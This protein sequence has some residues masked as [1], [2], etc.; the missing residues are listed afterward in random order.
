MTCKP[1]LWACRKHSFFIF[2]VVICIICNCGGY[3]VKLEV[4]YHAASIFSWNLWVTK[5]DDLLWH[6]GSHPPSHGLMYSMQEQYKL[7]LTWIL[8]LRILEWLFLYFLL[9]LVVHW[10]SQGVCMFQ[11]LGLSIIGNGRIEGETSFASFHHK[12]EFAM[13]KFLYLH[14][15][16]FSKGD[17]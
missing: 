4:V 3:D 5:L 13:S 14:L 8:C 16:N 10:G 1:S 2:F 12:L 9:G 6:S 11:I 17:F 7:R 15:D